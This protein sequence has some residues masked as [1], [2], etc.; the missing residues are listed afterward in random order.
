MVTQGIVT[1]DV[2]L[3]ASTRPADFEL[4]IGLQ[5]IGARPESAAGRIRR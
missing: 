4:Q 3:A 2:A 1:F 5:E